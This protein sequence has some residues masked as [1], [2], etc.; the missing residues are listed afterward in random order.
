MSRAQFA[1][2]VDDIDEAGSCCIALFGIE[3]A[4]GKPGHANVAIA[5]PPLKPVLLE[6]PL[7]EARARRRPDRQLPGSRTRGDSGI[8]IG[9][10]PSRWQVSGSVTVSER[11]S[12]VFMFNSFPRDR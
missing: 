9:K 8:G 10:R 1:L 6:N 7:R 4:K 3:P 2:N 11:R 5:E 12:I